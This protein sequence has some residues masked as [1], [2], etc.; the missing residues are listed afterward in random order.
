MA[1][2]GSDTLY[3]SMA[4]APLLSPLRERA[5]EL[6]WAE[7]RPSASL[8]CRGVSSHAACLATLHRIHHLR[9]V[10]LLSSR[11]PW[12]S[13]KRSRL[14]DPL[15]SAADFERALAEAVER[16]RS[17]MGRVKGVRKDKR[18]AD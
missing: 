5:I 16:R 6:R 3:A 7:W 12:L 10:V 15:A 8:R 9:C 4:P 14:D 1:T 17:R 11:I 13:I 18:H 2:V